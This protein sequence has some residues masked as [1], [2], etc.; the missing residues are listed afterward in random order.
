M[1]VDAAAGPER[2]ARTRTLAGRSALV[3]AEPLVAECVA[4]KLHQPFEASLQ[5]KKRRMD[6]AIDAMDGL[7]EYEIADVTAAATFYM[8]ETYLD[9]SRALNESERPAD[10]QPDE[11]EEYTQALE[12]EAF[13]FEEKAITFHQKNL[14]MMHAG[15]Y[16]PWTEK[17]LNKLVELVPGRYARSEQSTGFVTAMDTY[18]YRAPVAQLSPLVLGEEGAA[19]APKV[20]DATPR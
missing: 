12:T 7:V 4:V 14:E 13:P 6:A 8:A 9:F 18:V 19:P 2:T 17:S 15:V 20:D 3:L 11:V 10:L 1:K 5:E 16:N